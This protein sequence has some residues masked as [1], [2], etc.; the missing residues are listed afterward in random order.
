MPAHPLLPMNPWLWSRTLGETHAAGL[1]PLGTGLRLR[2]ARLAAL[3]REA[4]SESPFYRR[5]R[6]GPGGGLP[7]LE[8]IAPVEKAELMQHFDDWATDRRITRASVDD[9]LREPAHLGDAYLG[10]Y[11]VWT[12]SGTTGEPGIFVQDESSLAAFDALDALRLHGGPAAMRPWPAWGALPRYAFVAATG[13]HFAG[14]ASIER[15]RRIAKSVRAD[16]V[17]GTGAADLLGAAPAGRA[18]QAAAGLR[19]ERADHL[20]ELCRRA[21]AA[22]GRRARCGWRCRKY[23]SAANSCR[24]SS[25]RASARHS[26]AACTTTTVRPEFYAMAWECAEGCLHLN[27]DWLI[28]EPVDRQLRAVPP[29]EV[30]HSVLLT[31]LANRTQP[32]LRYR[33]GDSLRVLPDACACGSRLPGDRGAGPRRPHAGAAR[34][35]AARG[36][37]AAAG[38]GHGHRGRRAAHPLPAAVH[39]ARPA[40]AALRSRASPIRRPPSA[41]LAPR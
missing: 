39:R 24:P 7:R 4:F 29:G 22:A 8:Q 26:V 20:S 28:L 37:A 1:D 32:L 12:S 6:P 23:G 3:L 41:G 17:A 33:L 40:G 38:A 21:G 9:F 16:A 27:H 34:R 10:R 5:R 36:Q 19:A 31:N 11:L 25:A 30:S 15:L 13:G 18:G 35:A 14:A 2:D